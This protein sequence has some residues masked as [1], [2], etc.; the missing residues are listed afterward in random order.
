MSKQETYFYGQGKVKLAIIK[1]D[2][3]LQPYVWVGDVSSLKVGMSEETISH[4][5]SYSGKKAKVREFGYSAEASVEAVLHSIDTDN[6]AL[7]T[8]GTQTQTPEGTITAE[9]LPEITAGDEVVLLHP[10][11]SE[12]VI[13][14]STSVPVVVEPEHYTVDP[15]YGTIVF[16]SLP[17]AVQQPLK[18]AYK[19]VASKQVAFLNTTKRPSVALRYEGINLAE[20]GAP[21][22]AEFYKCAPSLLSDLALITD[23]N[24]VAGMPV[25]FGVLLDSSKPALGALGQFGRLIQVG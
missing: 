21:V 12:V 4:R 19:H 11:V 7:F 17:V 15:A 22:I 18:V 20:N 16:S 14:D 6:L 10:G 8:D 24:D 1:S 9:A 13:T 5:E 25:T 3:T 2:G 23:G